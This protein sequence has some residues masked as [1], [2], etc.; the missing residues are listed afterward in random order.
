M[1]GKFLPKV[2]RQGM[3][4]EFRMPIV[5]LQFQSVYEY[6]L[7]KDFSLEKSG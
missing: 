7:F 4:E 3:I 1:T 6:C 2:S 5:R